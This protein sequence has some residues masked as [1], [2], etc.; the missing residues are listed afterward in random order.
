MLLADS[1]AIDVASIAP[2]FEIICAIRYWV[3]L[4]L[5]NVNVVTPSIAI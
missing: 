4:N 2:K 3:G 1:E 5:P